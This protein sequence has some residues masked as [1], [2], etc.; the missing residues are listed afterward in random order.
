[1]TRADSRPGSAAPLIATWL[2][3]ALILGLLL[4]LARSAVGPLDDPDQAWQRPGFLDAGA[5]PAPAPTVV[6]GVPVPGRPT[7]VFF[8]RADGV[9]A[10]CRA[11]RGRPLP[12]NAA[13][14][15]V[16]GGA[17]PSGRC[18]HTATV[19][20]D[21]NGAVARAYGMRR[22]RAGGAP[23]GYAV[24]DATGAIRYRTLDP[25]VARH[26]G[27]VATIVEALR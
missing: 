7:V 16:V 8:I 23:V 21:A 20:I 5:L 22:P 24:V 6:E 11:L 27:E 17:S 4:V 26:L 9:G 12:D 25:E 14:V 2:G 10:L 13:T 18:A 3:A 1:M 15:L 19:F